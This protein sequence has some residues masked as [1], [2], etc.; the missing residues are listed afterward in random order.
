MAIRMRPIGELAKKFGD[1]ARAAAP[2]Y[3]IGVEAAGADWEQNTVAGEQNYVDGVNAAIGRKAFGK[4][5]RASGA[6]HYVKRASDLGSVR[7]GPGI[8]AGTDRWATNF[9]PFAQALASMTLPPPGPKRSPQ[10]QARANFVAAELGKMA[11]MK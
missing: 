8:Q 9:L 3:K 6:A 2:D 7:Y 10:N 1:R 11:E 4:G 5:V